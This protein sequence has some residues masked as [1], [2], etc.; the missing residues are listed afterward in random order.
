MGWM[1]RLRL[2]RA[3]VSA[4]AMPAGVGS[5]LSERDLPAET[6]AEVGGRLKE[7][8]AVYNGLIRS[9]I[10]QNTWISRPVRTSRLYEDTIGS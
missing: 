7:G 8:N 9:Q 1:R 4:G 10:E 5:I 6:Y 3:I 2:I